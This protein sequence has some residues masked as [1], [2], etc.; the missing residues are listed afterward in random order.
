MKVEALREAIAEA[1]RFIEIAKK[2]KTE[3]YYGRGP[4]KGQSYELVCT[5][6][7]ESAACKRASMDLTNALVRL[8]KP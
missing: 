4:T 1:E 5:N 6:T 3:T 8:R 7:R 2:V